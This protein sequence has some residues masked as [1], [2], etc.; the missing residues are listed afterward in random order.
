MQKRNKIITAPSGSKVELKEVKGAVTIVY[1]LDE[2]E[3]RIQQRKIKGEI[4]YLPA[5]ILTENIKEQL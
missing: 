4:G 2:N 5:I 3:E 1:Q